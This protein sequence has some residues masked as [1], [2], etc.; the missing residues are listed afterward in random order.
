[1]V[2]NLLAGIFDIFAS[3]VRRATPHRP[4]D[5][6][7]RGKQQQNYSCDHNR[8]VFFGLSANGQGNYLFHPVDRMVQ[9][10][11]NAYGA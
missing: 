9:P 4:E 8:S 10:Y 3:A 7:H 1:M 6:C 5:Q 11:P 2:L